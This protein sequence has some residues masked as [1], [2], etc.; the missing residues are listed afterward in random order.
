MNLLST[1]LLVGGGVPAYAKYP[2]L[3]TEGV[4]R[5]SDAIVKGEV[6]RQETLELEDGFLITRTVIAVASAVKEST[7]IEVVVRTPSEWS[8]A[9][10]VGDQVVVALRDQ[11]PHDYQLVGGTQS[12]FYVSSAGVLANYQ[13]PVVD[14]SCNIAPL[15]ARPLDQLPPESENE[16]GGQPV[17]ANG[18][19]LPD[20]R[21]F[22]Q[23][24][25]L[26][27]MDVVDFELKL[28]QCGAL[29]APIPHH[30]SRVEVSP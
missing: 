5:E 20:D 9:W 13:D 29:L 21:I 23:D 3:T 15:V 14:V 10:V 16:M 25:V 2:R 28:A 12:L 11:F 17:G 8:V 1:L 30:V 7:P 6:V 18:L 24:P 26:W 22:V 27:A 19:L 4:I